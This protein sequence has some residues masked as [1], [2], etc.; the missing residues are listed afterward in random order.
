MKIA[1]LVGLPAFYLEE[2]VF[3]REVFVQ[4]SKQWPVLSMVVGQ[5]G[6]PV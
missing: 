2:T 3:R 4:K 5:S 1:G 6:L